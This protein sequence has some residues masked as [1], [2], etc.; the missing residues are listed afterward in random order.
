MTYS[1]IRFRE[2]NVVYMLENRTATNRS[3]LTAVSVIQDTPKKCKKPRYREPS[4]SIE[5][6]EV[7]FPRACSRYPGWVVKPTKKSKNL[8]IDWKEI[9]DDC[10]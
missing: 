7:G 9:E 10:S 4:H 3:K 5:L 8:L 1:K 6:L 2:K